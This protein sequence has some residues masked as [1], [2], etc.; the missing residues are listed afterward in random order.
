M[1]ASVY[2]LIAA[3]KKRLSLDASL[4]PLLKVESVTLFEKTPLQ[5]A[6]SGSDYK[7]ERDKDYN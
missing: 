6:F 1:A 5:Q 7:S 4:L 2:V 3:V